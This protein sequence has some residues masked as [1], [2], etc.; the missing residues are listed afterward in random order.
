MTN[1]DVC[2]N[3]REGFDAALKTLPVDMKAG[4]K[5]ALMKKAYSTLI[6]C[7]GE[8]VLRVVTKKTTVAGIW[9]QLTS[10][11]M[12]KSLAKRSETKVT[13]KKT[14]SL[15]NILY[16]NKK[17]YTY[18]MSPGSK[19]CDHIDDFNKLILDFANIDIKIEDE[20][21]AQM[22]FTSLSS[23]YEKFMETLLYRRGS[24]T[25]KDVLETLNSREL[26]KRTEGTKEEIGDKLYVGGRSDCS[27]KAH[28][29]GSL[30]FKSR[31]GISKLKCFICHSRGHLKRD[32]LMKKLSGSVRMGKHDQDSDSSNDEG[33]VYFGE[34]LVVVG[35]DELVELVMD[36]GGSYH[37]KHRRDFLDRESENI[38][39]CGSSVILE[40]VRKNN[41]VYTLEAKA[42]TFGVQN[43][44]DS[45]QVRFKQ[46]GSKHVGFKQLGHKQVEFKK[47]GPRIET[48]VH[49]VS[50]DD[51]AM[52]Q[53]R[54]GDKQL[55]EKTN[56]DCLVKEQKNVQLGIKVGVDIMVTEVP[57]QEGAEGNAVE[58][59]EGV[60]VS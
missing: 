42:R 18:Y 46:L 28:S 5:V 41:C 4:E 23:S 55:E 43:H 48:G 37:M 19:L 16:L 60:Y 21:H 51:A 57:D 44:G 36:S 40:Y 9:T 2:F 7:L 20:D 30:R 8:R 15:A 26:K 54:L 39:A 58:K 32:R 6:L 33:N 45:K 52:A 47:L 27:R 35:N 53:R 24:L 13:K 59:N 11:D 14:K 25:M 34:A 56:T 17:L 22:L 12:T 29:G 1:K 31:G 50:N 10:L 3:G 49:G 38:G